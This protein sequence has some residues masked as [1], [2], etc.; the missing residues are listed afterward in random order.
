MTELTK[1][2][3]DEVTGATL[4]K[5]NGEKVKRHTTSLIPI[6]SLKEDMSPKKDLD[7]PVGGTPEPEVTISGNKR[8]A[9]I[10]CKKNPPRLQKC[11]PVVK[12]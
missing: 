7:T 8:A 4:L 5:G 11:M 12:L 2:I 1:N 3:N 9:A 10:E 6:L